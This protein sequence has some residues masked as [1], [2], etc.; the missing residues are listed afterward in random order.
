MTHTIDHTPTRRAILQKT[1]T[2]A[3]LFA[4]G[5]IARPFISTTTAAPPSAPNLP[6]DWPCFRGPNHNGTLNQSLSLLSTGPKKIW[7]AS[8]NPGNASFAIAANRLHTFGSRVDNLICLNAS[9][10]D[11]LWKRTL[12]THYGDSSPSLEQNRIYILA[13]KDG[14]PQR[15]IKQIATAHCCNAATGAV[16]WS[17]ELPGSTGDRQ[18]GHAGS[19][20]IWQ[21]L[22]FLNASG[23]AAV[24]KSN[25]ETLW[26]HPGFSGLAAPVLFLSNPTKKPAI[27]FF[28]GDR[29]LSRDARSGNLL[30]EIPWK[31]ELA[32]N[33]CD[34]IIFDDK[35]FI[36]SD[37]GRGRS[38]YDIKTPQP[39]LLWEFGAGKGSS[40]TSGFL[41][42]GNLFCVAESKF[43]CLDIESGRPKWTSD[44]ATSVLLIG[45]TLIRLTHKGV[46]SLARLSP[47]GLQSISTTDLGMKE[48]KA[49]PAYWNG[50]LYIRSEQGQIAC[51][52]IAESIP[53]Q[54]PP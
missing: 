25:G 2:T 18:Y 17:R 32:V 10:G 44:S 31:T 1:S 38:L 33:A 42:N 16:L 21:D 41:H 40:F 49:V 39:K 47:T 11:P 9:T 53:P 29:L 13:S 28:G 26:A 30:W 5:A 50:N 52:Q 51:L 27:A 45:D 8:V 12:D 7:E 3:A 20:L 43:M 35:V 15:G 23:G 46:L 22:I 6:A 14:I 19:P 37:Y 4:A 34:P 48:T 54:P 24:K 36:C